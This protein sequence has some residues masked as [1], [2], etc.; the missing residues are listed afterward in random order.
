MYIVEFL[1]GYDL[2]IYRILDLLLRNYFHPK[3]DV[4]IEHISLANVLLFSSKYQDLIINR[5]DQEFLAEN[6]L[7]K[8]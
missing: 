6:S 4:V 7:W 5:T 3:P 2:S 8:H 1:I